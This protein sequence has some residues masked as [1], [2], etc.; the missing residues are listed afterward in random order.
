[1]RVSSPLLSTPPS[2]RSPKSDDAPTS[3][4]SYGSN[5][6]NSSSSSHGKK[7]KDKQTTRVRTV[8]NENQL[9]T[10]KKCYAVNPRPDAVV[11]EQLVE[12]TG[13]PYSITLL[14]THFRTECPGDQG[15]VPEQEV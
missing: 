8:L 12:W 4:F 7:K 11:K 14:A 2:F 3:G 9:T 13:T 6:G 1:M 15:V 10:L 5:G